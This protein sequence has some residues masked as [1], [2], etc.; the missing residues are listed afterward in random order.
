[1]TKEL[2]AGMDLHSNNLFCG[3][4]DAQGK[5]VFEKKLPCALPQV[6]QALAP[7]KERLDTI[8][9]ESTYNWYW[10]VDGL[11]DAGHRV[12]LANPAGMQPYS[13]LKHSDDKSDA[14]WLAEMLRLKIKAVRLCTSISRRRN[15]S[16]T[17]RKG[18]S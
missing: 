5:R 10:L 4:V 2:M 11:Q 18:R 16:R 7:F 17:E 9:V 12:V 1:M 8:A 14:F 13:G 6:L 15:K 3:I